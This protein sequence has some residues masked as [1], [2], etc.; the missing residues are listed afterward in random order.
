MA[1]LR[2]GNRVNCVDKCMLNLPTGIMSC[3]LDNISISGAYVCCDNLLPAVQEGDECSLNLCNDPQ[4]C[5]TA[6]GC[7]V[8]RITEAGVGLRFTHMY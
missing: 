1:N 7:K 4:V 5:P 8:V 6:Y 2:H 3:R